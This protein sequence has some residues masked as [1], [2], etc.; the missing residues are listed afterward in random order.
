MSFFYLHFSSEWKLLSARSKLTSS[1]L[2]KSIFYSAYKGQLIS[3]A[4]CQAVNSSKKQTNEFVFT[5]MRP[6][7]VRFFE[8]IEDSQ[9]V[10]RNYLT[11]S[12][13]RFLSL[14]ILASCNKITI[15]IFLPIVRPLRALC[16][17][18]LSLSLPHRSRNDLDI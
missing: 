10:F 1:Y 3:K 13:A 8:E 12:T 14:T 9:E 15:K 7:F 6:V 18:L 17:L 11:F 5:T 4:N 2:I 16:S